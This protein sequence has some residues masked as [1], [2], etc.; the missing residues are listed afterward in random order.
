MRSYV[1]S[2][3]EPFDSVYTST[4][5]VDFE[6]KR[7]VIDNKPVNVQIWDTAGQVCDLLF[8]MLQYFHTPS[9]SNYYHNFPFSL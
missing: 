2:G 5:G 9:L 3:T 1:L 6:L 8:L 4:I 7:M